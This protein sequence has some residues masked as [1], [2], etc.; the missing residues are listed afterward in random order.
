[1][2]KCGEMIPYTGN[3]PSVVQLP[4]SLLIHV[5]LMHIDYGRTK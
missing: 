4:G 5:S 3:N 1:M 2:R